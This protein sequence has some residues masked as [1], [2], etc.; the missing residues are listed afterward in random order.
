[1]IA[2]GLSRRYAKAIFELAV[3]ARAEELIGQELQSFSDVLT[4]SPLGSVLNNPAYALAMRKNVLSQVTKGLQSSPLLIRFLSLLL[5]RRRLDSLPDIERRYKKLLNQAKGRIDAR[6]IAASPLDAHALDRVRVKLE[7]MSGKEVLLQSETD[8]GLIAG[9][10]VELEGKTY[11]GSVRAYL[12][13]LT[14]TIEHG[15]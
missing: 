8:P 9:L 4:G 14:D 7:Q 11:D 12:E 13:A 3:E 6:A 5:E 1:V 10:V 2:A 15:N